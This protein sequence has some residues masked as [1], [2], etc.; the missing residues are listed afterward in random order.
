MSLLRGTKQYVRYWL[1]RLTMKYIHQMDVISVYV[2]D[3]PHDK[4]YMEQREM[5]IQN[6]QKESL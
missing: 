3:E 5:L 4:I 6:K 2:Q 1:P